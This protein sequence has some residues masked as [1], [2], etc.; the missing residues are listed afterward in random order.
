M[1]F[2]LFLIVF[3]RA[4]MIAQY[5]S[6]GLSWRQFFGLMFFNILYQALAEII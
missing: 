3:N 4:F 6:I 5:R 2:T 1:E